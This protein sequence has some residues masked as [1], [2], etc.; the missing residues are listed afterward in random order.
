MFLLFLNHVT[1]LSLGSGKWVSNPDD[2]VRKVA[3][4]ELMAM[5]II[6]TSDAL[7]AD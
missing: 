2:V 6:P 5:F 7:A 1:K 3:P 4:D